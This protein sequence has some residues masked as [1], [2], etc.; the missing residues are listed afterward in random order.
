[1]YIAHTNIY[2]TNTE[3]LYWCIPIFGE[4]NLNSILVS[5][6]LYVKFVC[7]LRYCVCT[8]LFHSFYKQA[9]GLFWRHHTFS[10]KYLQLHAH[11]NKILVWKSKRDA[12]ACT[13]IKIQRWLK[14]RH[15]AQNKIAVRV[16]KCV[17]AI[18]SV[19]CYRIRQTKNK[20]F[21]SHLTH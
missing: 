8:F 9:N 19:L 15:I 18:A 21:F 20:M 13:Q 5:F 11:S 7:V 12:R 3:C 2:T 14:L 16:F 4:L 1:M 6:R 10:V 17:T